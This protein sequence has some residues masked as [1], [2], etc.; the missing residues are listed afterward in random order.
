[1]GQDRVLGLFKFGQR[2]HIDDLVRGTL[3][4]NPLQYFVETEASDPG[5]LRR[6][7]FEGV[8]RLIQSDGGILSMKI[9]DEFKPVAQIRGAIQW[10]PTGGIKANIYCMYALREPTGPQF[11]DP[12]NF[13]FG[14]T[15]A[16]FTDGDEFLR[17]VRTSAEA[18]SLKVEYHLVDYIN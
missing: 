15:F 16:I 1:M 4:M 18:A 13:R 5:D 3:Y 6:D 7:A 14:D 9:D 8:G 10:R 17:R 11:V 2:A 12:L